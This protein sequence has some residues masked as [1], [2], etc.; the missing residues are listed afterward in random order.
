MIENILYFSTS[1]QEFTLSFPLREHNLR[2]LEFEAFLLPTESVGGRR[3][4]SKQEAKDADL[5]G[6]IHRRSSKP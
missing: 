5:P 4:G 1:V 3:S 2:D 6:T